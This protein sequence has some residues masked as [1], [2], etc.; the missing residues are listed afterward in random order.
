MFMSINRKFICFIFRH[1]IKQ[2]LLISAFKQI[3]PQ[4]YLQPSCSDEPTGF[5]HVE[6][7]VKFNALLEERCNSICGFIFYD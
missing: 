1:F 4:L 3:T 6:G 5:K 2:F 7:N